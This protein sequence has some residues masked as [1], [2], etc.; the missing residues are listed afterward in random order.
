VD[1]WLEKTGGPGVGE[2]G[3]GGEGRCPEAMWIGREWEGVIKRRYREVTGMRVDNFNF[4]IKSGCMGGNIDGLVC[5]PGA[6]TAHKRDIR[7]TVGLEC[8][9][10]RDSMGWETAESGG[11]GRA[12]LMYEAQVLHYMALCPSIG[13]FDVFALFKNHNRFGLVGVERDEDTILGLIEKEDEWWRRHVIEG[14]APDPSCEGDCRKIWAKSARKA[15][16]VSDGVMKALAD[17]RAAKGCADKADAAMSEAKAIIM[18]HMGDSDTLTDIRGGTLA[19][20]SCARE[21]SM[22]DAD[23]LARLAKSKGATDEEV[24]QCH[25]TRKGARRFLVK[26]QNGG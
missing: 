12:P 25:E 23:K 3:E 2:G 20:W 24:A 4:I 26:S 9:A 7:A 17:Y 13:R 11:S 10:V 19:T 16:V 6:I 22:A 21:S 8:K 15:V 14:A 1:V 5:K 18:A